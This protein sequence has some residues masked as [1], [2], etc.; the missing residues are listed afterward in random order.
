MP[1]VLPAKDEPAANKPGRYLIVARCAAAE[2]N[3]TPAG[4]LPEVQFDITYSTANPNVFVFCGVVRNQGALLSILAAL[5]ERGLLL[6][7]VCLLE[8]NE[9]LEPLCG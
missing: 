3:C 2:S 9:L 5:I 6:H 4:G 7:S 1:T 8:Q